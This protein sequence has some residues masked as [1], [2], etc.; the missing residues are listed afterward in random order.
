MMKVI[1]YVSPTNPFTDRK[2][3]SG[4]TYKVRESIE[5]AGYE[6]VWIPYRTKSTGIRFWNLLLKIYCFFFAHG[7]RFLLGE[8][9]PWA[10]RIMARSIEKN[11]DFQRCDY[12]FFPGVAQIAKYLDTEKPYIYYSGATLPIMLDYYWFGICKLSRK[13]SIQIDREASLGAAINLKAS[14]WAL[15]SLIQDY[16]CNPSMCHVLEYGPAMDTDDITPIEPYHGG[17]LNI[18]FSGVDWNRKNGD[19]A[20]KTVAIL[21]ENGLD[22]HLYIA[23]I[24]NLPEYCKQLDYITYAGFLNKNTK[25][26]Y[27]EYT[28][29]YRKC[30]LLLVPT[31]AECAGVVFCEASA[32]GMPSYTYDTGGTTN[33]VI[34]GV[35]GRAISLSQGAERFAELIE[36]DLKEGKLQKFHEGALK[37]SKETLSWEKWSKK[38]KAIID[39]NLK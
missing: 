34:E 3:W 21:R 25:E 12:L 23:G 20:V 24:R 38:F 1:G 16:G 9:F 29:L 2:A 30:H 11:A 6:V 15:N 7:K 5:R 39:N 27:M 13:I 4:L 31:K 28:N 36:K 37:V 19:I 35:N 14:K 10:A 18:F 32:F 26:G 22:V 8:N 33:Y 17:T